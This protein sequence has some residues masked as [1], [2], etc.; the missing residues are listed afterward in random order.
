[1]AKVTIKLEDMLKAGLHL[2]HQA[3][4]WNP[5]MERYIYGVKEGVH[6]FD[7]TKTA[8]ALEEALA[9]L[10]KAA[11]DKKVILFVGTKKQA[12][13]RVQ[14]I[15]Q[16]FGY[17]Y[18]VE[19]WLGG[20]LTNFEQMARS[21]RT[22]EELKKDMAAG[23]YDAFTKKEKLLLSRKIAKMEKFFGGV[24]KMDKLPDVLF[25]VD[26]HKE[27]GAV[28]EATKKGIDIIGIVDTNADPAAVTWPIPANDDATSSLEYILDLVEKSLK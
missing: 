26:T 1:M 22:L 9:A 23:A 11:K 28:A 2:G 4:R 16:K 14:E 18:I 27:S 17:P 6:I 19:R 25:V 13:D 7:L 21:V 5:K 8:P 3:R 24:L 15:A 20:S 10:K 12:R